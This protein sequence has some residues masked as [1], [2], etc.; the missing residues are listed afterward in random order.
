MTTEQ[1]LVQMQRYYGMAYGDEGP[2]IE[3]YLQSKSNR[4]RAELAAMVIMRHSRK[5]KCLPDIAIFEECAKDVRDR[6][7][8]ANAPPALPEPDGEDRREEVAACL[9]GLVEKLSARRVE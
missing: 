2:V 1:F 9:R 6:M 5:W 4:W 8:A 7:S 3:R